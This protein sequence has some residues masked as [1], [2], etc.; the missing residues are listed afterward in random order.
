MSAGVVASF[1]TGLGTGLVAGGASCAAVQGGLLAGAVTDR[2]A[3]TDG[4]GDAAAR[5]A[6]SRSR[7]LNDHLAP[8]GLFLVGKL[9]SHTAFGAVLGLA[10][11]LLAPSPHAR[12]VLLVAASAL[13]VVFALD[14]IGV[15][16]VRRLSPRPPV[17]LL[18]LLRRGSRSPVPLMPMLLGLCTVALPCGITVSMELAASATGSALAGAAVM[19][20][21]VAGTGPL[22][23]VM[24]VLLRHST[25]IARGR[26]RIATGVLVA[27]VAVWTAVSGLRAGGWIA[28]SD[29]HARVAAPSSSAPSSAPPQGSA[30][31]RLIIGVS[32]GSYAPSL[33]SA[34]AGVATVLVLRTRHVT[35]CTRG[36]SIPALGLQRVLPATGEV[37]IDLGR[38]RPGRLR[39]SC[40]MG[41][42]GGAIDFAAPPG[43]SGTG[44]S[45]R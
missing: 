13:M 40:V 14:L 33:I 5:H 16:A 30:V 15:R 11:S 28:S 20:G 43:P 3:F 8:V 4:S 12:A 19:A 32:D 41:M 24:G 6:G 45:G 29:G 37:A 34:R 17:A 42:A 18:R 1:L 39:F 38:P 10:G 23:T 26:L 44:G 31:Q 21:F 36:F 2:T 25:R 22:F 7:S 35:G 9:I 27:A